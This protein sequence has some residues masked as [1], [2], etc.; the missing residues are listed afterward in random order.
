[1][2]PITLGETP[3]GYPTLKVDP[4]YELFGEFL[5]AEHSLERATRLL[6]TIESVLTGDLPEIV[7]WQ[8]YAKLTLKHATRTAHI[9]V[10]FLSK[11]TQ[12]ESQ[13]PIHLFHDIA[14]AWL[15]HVKHRQH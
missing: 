9:W 3:N 13:M 12:E 6:Q 15:N 5:R 2:L 14:A 1:M 4:P 7:V 11:G 8:D 10:D